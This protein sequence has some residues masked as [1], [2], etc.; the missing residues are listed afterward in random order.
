MNFLEVKNPKPDF[1]DRCLTLSRAIEVLQGMQRAAGDSVVPVYVRRGKHAPMPAVGIEVVRYGRDERVNIIDG[2]DDPLRD[3]MANYGNRKRRFETH[4]HY[5]SFDEDSLVQLR[6]EHIEPSWLHR[7]EWD[8]EG[9]TYDLP[10]LTVIHDQTH[11]MHG[12]YF[13]RVEVKE[14]L[15]V[16]DSQRRACEVATRINIL[17]ANKDDSPVEGADYQT[18]GWPSDWPAQVASILD[19]NDDSFTDFGAGGP[20]V[21]SMVAGVE[22]RD[23]AA[24]LVRV[25][26]RT[27]ANEI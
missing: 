8:V 11:I 25:Q 17:R 13:V 1:R 16:P 12:C 27:Y 21:L 20:L 10:L 2:A 14:G 26:R 6:E 7:A 18:S 22:P 23:A 3:R 4:V 5:F 15:I 24:M 9:G 19:V